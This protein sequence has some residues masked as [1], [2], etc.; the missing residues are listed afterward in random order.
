[1]AKAREPVQ[2]RASKI[3]WITSDLLLNTQLKGPEQKTQ[4][5]TLTKE[6]YAAATALSDGFSGRNWLRAERVRESLKEWQK[7]AAFVSI[8]SAY[9]K[10]CKQQNKES[11][12]N[13]Q[14]HFS[15]LSQ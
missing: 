9:E 12:S 8:F 1:A 3:Q 6:F 7:D 4:V 5:L 10:L 13:C 15:L 14:K 11:Q 2:G